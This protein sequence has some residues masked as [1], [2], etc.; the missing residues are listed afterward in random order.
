MHP[1]TKKSTAANHKRPLSTFLIHSRLRELAKPFKAGNL[2][3]HNRICNAENEALCIR[4]VAALN[5][6]DIRNATELTNYLPRLIVSF[7]SGRVTS[8]DITKN[9]YSLREDGP[10][11]A[12]QLTY[13]ESQIVKALRNYIIQGNDEKE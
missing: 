13:Q 10:P 4:A 12:P 9:L 2:L 1:I 5:G 6:A 8:L 7:R 3:R 11:M